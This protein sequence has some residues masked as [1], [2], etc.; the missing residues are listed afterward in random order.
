VRLEEVVEPGA[1]D[2]PVLADRKQIAQALLNLLLNAAYVSK[3]GGA[4]RVRA[5]ARDGFRGIAVEDD[6][7]GIPPELRARVFEPFFTTKP[8]GE[9]T[10]LGLPLTRTIVDLHHGALELAFPQRGGTVATI[11]LPVAPERTA[12][13]APSLAGAA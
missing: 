12:A 8:G 4:V 11:W 6:G 10:G 7:P 3:P 1:G 5:T 2:A 9:G 13:A